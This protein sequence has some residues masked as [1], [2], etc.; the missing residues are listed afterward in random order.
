MRRLAGRIKTAIGLG[1]DRF[2]S[3]KEREDASALPTTSSKHI[4]V[5]DLKTAIAALFGK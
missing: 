3:P 2:I 1:F 5:R 4:I